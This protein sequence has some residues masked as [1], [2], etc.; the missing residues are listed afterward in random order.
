MSTA[1]YDLSVPVLLF[2]ITRY[3]LL[4]G[5][6]GA[7]RSLGRVGVTSHA[8]ISSTFSPH[9]FSRHLARAFVVKEDWT[10]NQT[11]ILSQLV[12]IGRE[13]GNP[14]IL[15]PTDDEAAIFAAEHT[16]ELRA[17]FLLPQVSS[18]LPR[19]LAS[20]R[21]LYQLCI[22]HGVPAPRTAF[23]R[24]F[25][26]TIALADQIRYPVVI[27][28]SEPWS[29]LSSPA[30][31]STTIFCA[32]EELL[33]LKYTWPANSEVIIQ[34]YIPDDAA[35]D[36][37]VHVY[38]GSDSNPVVAFT[39]RKYQ[40]WPPR[41]GVTTA[42]TVLRNDKLLDMATGFC[43]AVGFKGIADMDWRF[44]SRDGQYKLVD[45]NPR[46]GAN[47]RL[48]VTKND[49]DVVRALH[50][51]LTG[52]AVPQAPPVFGRKFRLENLNWAS[53]LFGGTISQNETATKQSKTEY[54]WLAADD[55]LPFLMMVVNFSCRIIERAI[56][57]PARKATKLVAHVGTLFH[58]Q[59]KPRKDL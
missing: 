2:P 27:K 45:F 17:C 56:S 47:F 19:A 53:R 46:F 50:L 15:L 39:G 44:D 33:R 26:E 6:L 42:A 24:S 25:G 38:C 23:A 52:R 51:D 49:I 11:A 35:E 22:G 40:S 41:A 3:S 14:V 16:D 12:N 9:R 8:I 59:H 21:D 7:I 43:R 32:A 31:A 37:I 57:I 29:R 4:Y 13:L 54:A 48:F 10:S 20:K 5:S 18:A 28:N 1:S 34:E 30:V 36:W 55:P 58:R